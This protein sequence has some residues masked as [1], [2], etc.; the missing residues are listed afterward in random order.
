MALLAQKT[1]R[2]CGAPEPHNGFFRHSR[3]AAITRRVCAPCSA[4][5]IREL[6]ATMRV[7]CF[8]LLGGSCTDC[9]EYELEFLT[10]DHIHN[11]GH[12]ERAT[13]HPDQ[14]KRAILNGTADKARYRILCRNCNDADD[15]IN[16]SFFSKSIRNQNRR[17]RRA[18]LKKEVIEL[19]GGV[20]T[21]CSEPNLLKLTVDHVANDGNMQTS[22]PRGSTDLYSKILNGTVTVSLFQLLCWNCNFS[23][24]LGGGVCIH[25]RR[26]GQVG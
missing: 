3:K 6:N 5:Q 18:R 11:D 25:Q 10:I 17:L 19:L 2:Y 23:K 1:C 9:G 15:L 24:H 7:E 13:R 26:K 20:C 4:R 21:C 8:A 16:R 22:L 12:V 14:I